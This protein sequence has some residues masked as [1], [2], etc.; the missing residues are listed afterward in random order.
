MLFAAVLLAAAAPAVLRPFT[1]HLLA[2]VL[3]YGTWAMSFGLV[4]G[5]LG[6]TSFGHAALFGAGGY[7]AAWVGLNLSDNLLAGLGRA[8]ALFGAMMGAGAWPGAGPAVRGR[9]LD[10]LA[11]VRRHGDAGGQ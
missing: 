6:L 9:V 2:L 7:A 8:A 11:G 4:M 3:C 5:Q 10:R 1:L